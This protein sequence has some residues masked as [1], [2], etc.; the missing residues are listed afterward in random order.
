MQQSL[1][2]CQLSFICCGDRSALVVSCGTS[3]S[4]AKFTVVK[5]HMVVLTIG[6]VVLK[7]MNFVNAHILVVVIILRNTA[8]ICM[9]NHRN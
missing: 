8:W 9:A 6:A 5:M 7:S 1:D 3:L 2:A 4:S